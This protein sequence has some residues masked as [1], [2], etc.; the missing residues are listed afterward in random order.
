M[1]RR[2]RDAFTK[3]S[4]RKQAGDCRAC[5]QK[6]RALG[7]AEWKS[8]RALPPS[9]TCREIARLPSSRSVVECGCPLPLF[10]DPDGVTRPALAVKISGF[11]AA[12]VDGAIL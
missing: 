7:A 9:K 3:S 2:E 6:C 11:M 12:L 4:R 1:P 10:P 5:G 8:G